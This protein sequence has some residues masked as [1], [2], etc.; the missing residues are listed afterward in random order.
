MGPHPWSHA[1]LRP[2]TLTP[3]PSPFLLGSQLRRHILGLLKPSVALKKQTIIAG[4]QF[5]ATIYVLMK[6]SLQVRGHHS[7]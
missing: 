4:R 5:G 6:G 2:L 1:P 3:H 7:T